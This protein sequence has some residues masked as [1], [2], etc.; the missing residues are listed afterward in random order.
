[1]KYCYDKGFDFDGLYKIF[2]RVSCWCCPLQGLDEL[3]N[4]RKFFPELWAELL[5][6]DSR[7]WRKFRFDYSV[8]ELDVMFSLQDELTE[9][10][11][12]EGRRKQSF[13]KLFKERLGDDYE[14]QDK[15]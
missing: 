2:D 1:M 11:K 8:K 5:D 14:G 7:T 9:Q 6:M 4:L 15:T 10:G 3:Y 12:F 13:R